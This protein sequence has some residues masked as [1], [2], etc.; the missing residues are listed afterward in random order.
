MYSLIPTRSSSA[1]SGKKL[2][3]S[4]KV[5]PPCACSHPWPRS[6]V[7]HSP[8]SESPQSCLVPRDHLPATK[9][10]GPGHSPGSCG[11]GVLVAWLR[12]CGE[13]TVHVTLPPSWPPAAAPGEPV[14]PQDRGEAMGGPTCSHSLVGSPQKLHGPCGAGGGCGPARGLTGQEGS[15]ASSSVEHLT[16]RLEGPSPDFCQILLKS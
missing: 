11:P 7:F 8:M 4:E 14:G 12:A 6:C 2:Q 3:V 16:P 13:A 15:V 5:L 1:L 10:K 9:E